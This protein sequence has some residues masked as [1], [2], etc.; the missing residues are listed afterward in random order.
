M[1]MHLAHLLV[2]QKYE[3]EDLLKRLQAGEKFEDL[4]KKYS[5]CSSA[6]AGGDLGNI[7]LKRLD[8]RFAEAAEELQ[9]GALSPIVRTRFGYH[10]IWRK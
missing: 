7:D 6:H 10:L 1:K 9:E 2:E 3:A 4:A 5:R 8:P